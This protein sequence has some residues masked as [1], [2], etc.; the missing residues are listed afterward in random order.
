MREHA[1]L[2][3][4]VRDDISEYKVSMTKSSSL[5]HSNNLSL[6]LLLF[7]LLCCVV[8][9]SQ[10]HLTCFHA[11]IWEHVPKDAVIAGES[12]HPW[13]YISCKFKCYSLV[14]LHVCFT[15][16]FPLLHLFQYIFYFL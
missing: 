11:G 7:L 14:R 8:S 6:L 13:K 10:V 16:K 1:E 15:K 3:S 9:Q 2:L 12:S 4:S 5:C